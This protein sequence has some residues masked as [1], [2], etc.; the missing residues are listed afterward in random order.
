MTSDQMQVKPQA[1]QLQSVLLTMTPQHLLIELGRCGAV[2]DP[3]WPDWGEEGDQGGDEGTKVPEA[4]V[5]SLDL[6]LS[7]NWRSW[8]SVEHGMICAFK[9]QTLPLGG[10]GPGVRA[11][12]GSR[13][14]GVRR[15][16]G[17]FR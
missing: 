14:G 7:E 2:R 6:V 12:G 15:L 5:R 16:L 3:R 10:N 17:P 4:P 8:P 13:S 11:R 1:T 9:R